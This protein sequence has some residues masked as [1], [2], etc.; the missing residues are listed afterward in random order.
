MI[1]A[2][3]STIITS[4]CTFIFLCIVGIFHNKV[5]KKFPSNLDTMSEL[6][7]NISSCDNKILNENL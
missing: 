3:E 7:G 4:A 2:D 6:E 1:I 5:K